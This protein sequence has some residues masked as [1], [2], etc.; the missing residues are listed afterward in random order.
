[1]ESLRRLKNE[2]GVGLLDCKKALK[3]ANGDI[4]SARKILR[5]QGILDSLYDNQ[6]DVKREGIIGSYTRGDI[7]SM[8]E[9]NCMKPET[10]RNKKFIEFANRLCLHIVGY[11]PRYIKEHE[12]PF[13]EIK[14]Q[15]ELYRKQNWKRS[16]KET[17]K[18]VERLMETVYFPEMCLL[19]QTFCDEE[20]TVEERLLELGKELNDTITINRFVRWYI[21]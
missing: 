2:T 1:M 15:E 13:S 4:D 7:A 10:S 19:L 20:I 14:L 3:E 11:N 5:E 17:Q 16:E 12:I 21:N 8:V 18:E 9:L 6:P